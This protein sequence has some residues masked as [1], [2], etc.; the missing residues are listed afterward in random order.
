MKKGRIFIPQIFSFGAQTRDL[1][2][3]IYLQDATVI[4]NALRALDDYFQLDGIPCYCDKTLLAHALGCDVNWVDGH[5]QVRPMPGIAE[6]LEER[7]KRMIQGTRLETAVG[8]VRSLSTLLPSKILMAGIPGP[9]MLAAQITGWS[10]S[11]LLGQP[12]FLTMVSS[13]SLAALGAL[14]AERVDI[15]TFWEDAA[16]LQAAHSAGLLTRCYSPIFSLAQHYDVC[17]LLSVQGISGEN[18]LWLRETVDG[19]L[20]PLEMVSN[21][22]LGECD[23]ISVALPGSLLLETPS[24]IETVFEKSGL[25]GKNKSFDVF[26]FT[27]SD[28]IGAAMDRELLITGVRTIRDLLRENRT[29]QR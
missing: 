15:V 18:A 24:R 10:V 11:D 26:L 27:S 8:V 28:E 22:N 13:V 21:L 12:D 3:D 23:R 2:P 5:L 7:K 1:R 29:G 16:W 4:V 9:V 14:G 17:V 20:F 19:V 6:D 25:L